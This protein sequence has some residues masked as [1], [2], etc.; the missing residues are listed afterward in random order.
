MRARGLALLK[1]ELG[2][3]APLSDLWVDAFAVDGGFGLAGD[4]DAGAIFIDA[5]E[6]D[7]F[8]AVFVLGGD[9]SG[10][11]GGVSVGFEIVGPVGAARCLHFSA[12]VKLS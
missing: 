10:K 5:K 6:D 9:W 1:P 8:G 4:A 2:P 11:G 3:G 12:G 7:G